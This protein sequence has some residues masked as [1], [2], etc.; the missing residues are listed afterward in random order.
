MVRFPRAE[1]YRNV[2]HLVGH[3]VGETRSRAFEIFKVLFPGGSISGCPKIRACQLLEEIEKRSRELYTGSMG[4]FSFS[5]DA[6]FNI[7]IRTLVFDGMPISMASGAASPCCLTR[8]V[9]G[10]RLNTRRRL[11]LGCSGG[12]NL[13]SRKK[14][15]AAR[16]PG[17]R[18]EIFP[19][20]EACK[21]EVLNRP[22]I[23]Y[24]G[25][26][27]H[28]DAK[29]WLGLHRGGTSFPGKDN[30]SSIYIDGSFKEGFPYAGWGYVVV[31]G[32]RVTYQS[33]GLTPRPAQSRNVDGELHAALMAV[34]WAEEK[35][36]RIVLHYDYTGVENWAI[37]AWQARSAA[38]KAYVDA[39]A[40]H[41]Q[42][43]RFK[44]VASHSGDE[45][46]DMADALAK[47]AIEE[48]G[49]KSLHD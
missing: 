43:V 13:L 39:I 44:K 1:S 17:G 22:G 40:P 48:A 11:C 28:E 29:K 15:Y 42:A 6:D 26:V 18:K 30:G 45:Y 33:Y 35:G 38:A 31:E 25:F 37:G 10:K 9:N 47:R 49:E 4:Y 8:I 5:G 2:H 36:R 27:D 46:N 16:F 19:S 7:L 3:I 24:K 34:K 21:K 23:I 20:W 32:G 12:I 41:L 14:Y